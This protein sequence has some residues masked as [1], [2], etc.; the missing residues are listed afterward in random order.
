MADRFPKVS[1]W[2]RIQGVDDN[3][4][5]KIPCLSVAYELIANSALRS[6]LVMSSYLTTR[7]H[8]IIVLL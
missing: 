4:T 3:T 7:A 1:E 2:T 5:P 6:S 8:G